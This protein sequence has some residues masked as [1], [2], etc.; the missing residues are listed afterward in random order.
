MYI[1][2]YKM[3]GDISILFI[4]MTMKKIYTVLFLFSL[5][6]AGFS[7]VITIDPALPLDSQPVTVFFHAD[8]GNKGLMNYSG[9]DVYAHT[10]V[11]TDKSTSSSDWK[12]VKAEWATNLP[13]CKLTKN[14][15]NEYQLSITPDIRS[16]YGVPE[17]EK[18][19]KMAFVFRN[20]NGGITG[21]DAGGTDIF[22]DVYAEGL[23]VSFI[24][25]SERFS[26]AAE[27]EVIPVE[28]SATGA[29]SLFLFLDGSLIHKSASVSF[30][31][32]IQS[33]DHQKHRLVAKASHG[34]D[35]ASDTIWYMVP[36]TTVQLP[37][38]AGLQDGITYPANDSAVFI[39][40][41]PHKSTI[42]LL[43]D[44]NDWIPDSV[45][46]LK[47]DGD[48]FWLGIGNLTPGKEYAFQYLVDGQIRIADPYSEKILDPDN[49][50]YIPA[51]VYPNLLSY[52]N[53][54]TQ[55]ITGVI[56][57]GKAQ[58]N[59]SENAYQPPQ[60]GNLIIYELLIRDFIESHNI[61]DVAG[62]L[63]YLQTLGVNAIELMPFSEFEGNSSWGYN[64]SFY[65]APDKYYGRDIDF[66][67][68]IDECH[69]RGMAVIMD[70]V[71]NHAYGQ[72]PMV[73][74]YFDGTTGKPTAENPWFNVNSPNTVY[75]WGNDF[76]H[77]SPA[78]QYFV[79]RV[80]GY[81][82]NEYKLDGFRFDFTKGFTNTTGDGSSYDASR[83][84]ILERIY[85]RIKS[86]NPS[87][88]MICEHFAPNS[89]EKELSD[90]GLMLWG[91]S[92]YN[93][94]E[95]TMGYVENSD[96]S[97]ASYKSRGWTNPNL[98]SYMESHDEERLM[99]KNLSYGNSSGSY[100]IKDLKTAL[101]REEL[102]GAFFFTIPGPKMIWQ[103]GELG[104]DISI[105]VNGRV[106]EKPI[107][108]DY[109][110]Q[111]DRQKLYY[112]WAKILDI[113][114]NYSVFQTNDYTM[115][116]G[117]N[118]ATKKIILHGSEED[119][120][121]IG[122]FGV[123]IASVQPGFASAGWWYELFSGDSLNVFD[124]SSSV[125]LNPGEYRLYA[126]KKMTTVI[127]G[128]RDFNKE[129]TDVYPNP[130]KDM[131]YF[132]TE[133]IVNKI[134]VFNVSGKEVIARMYPGEDHSIDIS[135]LQGGLYIIE[136]TKQDK[137]IK[138]KFVKR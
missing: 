102:A 22:T 118:D 67:A 16:F 39:L 86:V 109:A 94:N 55:G 129:F 5:F 20:G 44:F 10:G 73:K 76:N 27:A 104:Y 51:S 2:A 124:I 99:F 136:I 105:D 100:N 50:K 11:I 53:T 85:D 133:G 62:K 14:S 47:K 83:I 128:V 7:Q 98:V 61:K 42:Y 60:P 112:T 107:R 48:R 81:W 134:S 115:T 40:F 32:S 19:L 127:S 66:K 93:Y 130:A 114:K 103:F 6:R 108:W 45:Y 21:R 123:T 119:A 101:E 12:Y 24:K 87:A 33:Q 8:L 49:D 18:I 117:N 96:F 29:D 35:S 70:I 4:H 23:N 135:G 116:V 54:K 9:T 37:M 25:P 36:G 15:A 110:D 120:L 69:N 122:N 121:V 59:W 57:P 89:E 75:S 137:I 80:V 64:P 63:D 68:F 17:N 111:P 79:D 56:Q 34:T 3:H 126:N 82:L 31:T 72:N 113:R 131:L 84:S 77:E 90:Y 71:L 28:V 65:F 92:N 95:A 138:G 46:Q 106:G 125:S 38:P 78:T 74:L 13:A 88:A 58:F 97:W 52:P 43:G 132:N 1:L 41:A 30:D 26:L 91:N